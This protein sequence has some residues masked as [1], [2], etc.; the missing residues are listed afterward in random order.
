MFRRIRIRPVCNIS[1]SMVWFLACPLSREKVEGFC[2]RE[3]ENVTCLVERHS[4][5]NSNLVL[6]MREAYFLSAFSDLSSGS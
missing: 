5:L 3:T 1:I 6:F 2:E 4:I